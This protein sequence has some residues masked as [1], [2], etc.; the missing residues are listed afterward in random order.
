MPLRRVESL[1][2]FVTTWLLCGP[3]NQDGELSSCKALKKDF[4]GGEANAW[5][6]AG[7]TWHSHVER[8][9]FIVNL[10]RFYSARGI[11]SYAAAYLDCPKTQPARILLG[12]DD[13]FLLYLN[14]ARVGGADVHRGLG[15]D[16]DSFDV[17]LKKGANRILL[18]IE[19]DFGAYEF[20][21]RVTGP[22]G[23]AVRGLRAFRDH[24]G[25]KRTDGHGRARTIS[26]YD[27]LAHKWAT[28]EHELA[29]RATTLPQYRNWKKKFIARLKALIGPVPRPC[30]LRP[31]ITE[32]IP[33]ENFRRRRVL[34]DLEPGFAFPCYVTVPKKGTGL[35]ALLCLHGHG[36][37]KRDMVGALLGTE[38]EAYF[39]E[40]YAIALH[41]ARKGYVTIS[42]DFLAFGERKGAKDTYGEGQDPC[43]A[44]LAWGQM[45]GV[46]PTA[47]NIAAVKRC[48]D[49]LQQ[50]PEVD[51]RRIAAAGHSFGGYMTTMATAIEPRIKVAVI[52]GFMMT[53]AA[54]HGRIWNCGSQVVPGLLQYGD[55]SDIACTFA[56][57]PA[58]VI[59]GK[60]DCVTPF[61]FADAAC[62]K[63][64]RAYDVAGVP[65][66]AGQHVFDGDHVFQPDAAMDWLERWL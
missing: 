13:G 28:A 58:L 59:T 53:S 64:Q 9:G 11:V 43:P 17:K 26:S 7:S 44:Q 37:G 49:F 25:A 27:Y 45:A 36:G 33:V 21:L 5:P 40:P 60:Y 39:S 32:D 20:C 15:V 63:I 46:L 29:F 38:H 47:V 3:F 56:P 4:L 48:I 22:G 1:S 51:G 66:R 61:P 2:G 16:S 55:L 6:R 12:S 52:S 41:A 57:R 10:S 24:P 35:P 19:Q 62:K 31:E 34:L 8:H 14:G 50:M 23:N 42:P 65:E 54:Y 30:P 18:K